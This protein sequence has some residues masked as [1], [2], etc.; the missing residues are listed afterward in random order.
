MS[1]NHRRITFLAAVPLAETRSGGP[2]EAEPRS[3]GVGRLA[4]ADHPS[5][6]GDATSQG[7]TSETSYLA[8]ICIFMVPPAVLRDCFTG[9]KGS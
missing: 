8:A 5:C 2:A 9:R 6:G 1:G 3:L 7:G 4:P